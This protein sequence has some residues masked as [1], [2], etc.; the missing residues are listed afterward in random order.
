MSSGYPTY[1]RE[2]N[3]MVI[4]AAVFCRA[5]VLPQSD[6]SFRTGD[7]VV[8]YLLVLLNQMQ[9]NGRFSFS[10]VSILPSCSK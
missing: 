8:S 2:H 7:T 5:E 3:T 1:R 9:S 6:S 10:P 4:M